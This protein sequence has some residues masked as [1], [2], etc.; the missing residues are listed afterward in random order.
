MSI[1][2]NISLLKSS[3]PQS[4]RLVAVSKTRSISEILDAYHAGQSIFG[5]NR[6]QEIQKKAPLLPADIEW[7]LIGHLQSNKVKQILPFV[8]LIHSV[9]SFNLLQEINREAIKMNRVIP[10]LIQFHIAREESKTGFS[11]V[12]FFQSVSPLILESLKN[13]MINGVM[14]I[15]SFTSD[16]SIVRSEFQLLRKIYLILK[17]QYFKD[18][19]GFR[20]ISM[21][22]SDDYPIAIEEGSTLIRVGTAIFGSR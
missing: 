22:M 3:L 18:T 9:D 10:C 5:E 8:S 11:T 2:E 17:D 20:D 12:E 21:G 14:G 6:V 15:A 1:T 19:P 7:H 13:V 16:E 4:V